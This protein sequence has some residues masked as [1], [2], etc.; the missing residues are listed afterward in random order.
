M[1]RF[2]KSFSPLPGVRIT[3]SPS[4]ISTSV[5]A[6]PFRVTAGPRGPHLTT[7]V[8]GTGLSHRQPLFN[9]SAPPDPTPAVPPTPK[10]PTD[11]F[12]VPASLPVTQIQS[13]GSGVLTTSGLA[14]FRKLIDRAR[15]EHAAT[16]G[17]LTVAQAAEQHAVHEHLSWK[18]GWLLR[19][20][21][22]A[23]FAQLA[24][25]AEEAVARR[26]ELDEQLSLARLDTQIDLSAPLEGAYSRLSDAFVQLS[27]SAQIWDTISH[28]ETNQFAER[29]TATRSVERKQVR[30]CLGQCD[31]ITSDWQV[32]HLENANGGD[33]FLYPAFIVYFAGESSFALLEYSE[34]ELRF[35]VT[36]FHED[37]AVPRDSEVVGKTWAKANKDGSCDLRFKDNY[38]IPIARYGLLS[39]RS[40]TGLNEEYMISNVPATE[41]FAK[42][43]QAFSEAVARGA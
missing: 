22:K 3:L 26:V 42:D 14:E 33:T 29:T 11:S 34:V 31:V 20:I 5:G 43:W 2:R 37:E 17:E 35:S 16:A 12:T 18:N 10:L 28:R 32:P 4:G 36:R 24:A 1:W 8:L 19:R 38:E 41:A 7:N 23:R 6:G 25:A 21:M 30:F 39:L 13:A 40:R 15:K 27:R 9:P